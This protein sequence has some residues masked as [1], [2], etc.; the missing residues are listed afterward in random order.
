MTAY[1]PNGI[2]LAPGASSLS[3]PIGF[4]GIPQNPASNYTTA[5]SFGG[6]TTVS[7]S[8]GAPPVTPSTGP[9]NPFSLSASGTQMGSNGLPKIPTSVRGWNNNNNGPANTYNQYGISYGGAPVSE[10]NPYGLTPTQQ[11]QWANQGPT[12]TPGGTNQT[13]VNPYYK[14]GQ[15]GVGATPQSGGAAM[16]PSTTPQTGGTP[17]P[18]VNG[19]IVPQVG[20]PGVQQQQPSYAGNF[21]APNTSG[22]TPPGGGGGYVAGYGTPAPLGVGATQASNPF[23]L[24]AQNAAITAGNASGQQSTNNIG[25]GGNM[26]VG[27]NMLQSGAG[28][29][30]NTAFDPQKALY[31]RTAQQL[32]D[33]VRVGEAARGITM[34]PYGA[35][36]E[37]KA[38]SD[39]NIDWQNA[40]LARQVSGLGAAGTGTNAAGTANITG[41]N[42][43]QQGVTQTQAAGAMPWDTY[44]TQDQ[45]NIQNWIAYMNQANAE[46]GIAQQAYPLQLAQQSM[47][48]AGGVPYIP[49]NSNTFYLA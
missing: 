48:Q 9:Q 8:A 27:A 32:Q 45:T 21:G 30:M 24:T 40:Q 3:A 35:G 7:Q 13:L 19:G 16:Q 28:A 18:Q 37:N 5:N 25:Q 22:Y 26:N 42:L 17:A 33:Q 20:T 29:V 15:T 2:P 4:S 41:A 6:Q 43:G 47:S 38:M 1:D 31:D 46:A 23:G 44:N 39:F 36:V 12:I 11:A 49:Q 10:S 34:S 14:G